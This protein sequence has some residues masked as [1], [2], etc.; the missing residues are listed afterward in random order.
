[1]PI[2]ENAENV[3][4]NKLKVDQWKKNTKRIREA[5]KRK[6]RKYIGLLPILG[7]GSTP[8]PI[9][10]RFFPKEKTFIA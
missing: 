5:F 2:H 7:G 9:Y 4:Q 6:K 10:F 8:R 3:T 1:M